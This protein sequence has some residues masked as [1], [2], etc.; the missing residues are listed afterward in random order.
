MKTALQTVCFF[1]LF[2][3]WFLICPSSCASE[4][5]VNRGAYTKQNF[6]VKIRGELD[7]L[8]IEGVLQSRPDAEGES[9]KALFRAE[10]PQSLRGITVSVDGNGCVSAR[11]GEICK[12]DD[13][14]S[15]I[16][17]FFLPVCEMGEP[18]SVEKCTDGG[19]KIRVCDEKC[20]LVYLFL[21]ESPL[22]SRIS[23]IYKGKRMDLSVAKIAESDVEK[24]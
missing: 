15:S 16:A 12:T 13:S 23:G 3:F 4:A 19:V 9:I 18:Y 5:A 11:L 20:D 8:E 17:D 2:F 24:K 6:D 21:P 14:F 1:L 10:A 7:G 22:P